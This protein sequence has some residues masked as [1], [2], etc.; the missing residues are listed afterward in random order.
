MSRKKRPFMPLYMADFLLDTGHLNAA[1]TG[2]YLLL[3]M[4][5][6]M[7]GQ[8]P[9]DDVKLARIARMTGAQWGRSKGVIKAFFVNPT[10]THLRIDRELALAAEISNKR[11]GAAVQ[12][13]L[14]KDA[15]AHTLH[16]SLKESKES[17]PSPA[18]MNGTATILSI[19]QSDWPNDYFEQFWQAYPKHVDKQAAMKKLAQ[20]KKGGKLHWRDL[21]DGTKR[22]AENVCGKDPQF[23]KGPASWL[24]NGKWEDETT[25]GASAKFDIRRHILS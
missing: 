18:A 3:I 13:H 11:K 14:S 15:N 24:N 2:A 16:T 12:M 6:W 10:M 4:S 20:L 5:Y 21:I 25:V 23:T 19:I 8:L 22:Y 7:H 9:V 17:C 1:E